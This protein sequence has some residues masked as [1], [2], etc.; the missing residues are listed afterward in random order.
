VDIDDVNAKQR[1]NNS[2]LIKTIV[3]GISVKTN[4]VTYKN[5]GKEM[6]QQRVTISMHCQT[7]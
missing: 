3:E 2:K 5:I 7:I 4:K 6:Q 1:K